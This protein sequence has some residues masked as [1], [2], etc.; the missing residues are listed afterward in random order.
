MLRRGPHE[1]FRERVTITSIG[2]DQDFLLHVVGEQHRAGPI[3]LVHA[4]RE[5]V[6]HYF[7]NQI[8]LLRDIPHPRHVF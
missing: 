5:L 7:P 1:Q 6:G 4:G 8:D 2:N 3:I